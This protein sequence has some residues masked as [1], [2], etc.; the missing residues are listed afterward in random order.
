VY[1]SE[2]SVQTL[3]YQMPLL[4]PMI[5]E[6]WALQNHRCGARFEKFDVIDR[7]KAWHS[8]GQFSRKIVGGKYPEFCAI[9]AYIQVTT[10]IHIGGYFCDVESK[11]ISSQLAQ[12]SIVA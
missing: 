8:N 11:R 9:L 2:P 6:A 1:S 4:R 7:T 10:D 5:V 3:R 12:P